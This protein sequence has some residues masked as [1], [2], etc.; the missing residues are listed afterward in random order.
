MRRTPIR[1]IPIMLIA[2]LFGGSSITAAGPTRTLKATIDVSNLETMIL[3][4]GV[5]DVNISSGDTGVVTV[6]VDL[7]PRRGGIFSSLKAAEK[8]VQKVELSSEISGTTLE[9]GLE[10]T[11]HDR[12]FEEDWTITIPV[13]L[14]VGIDLGVGDVTITGVSGAI[15]LELGVGDAVIRNFE[16]PLDIELGVGDI[17]IQGASAVCREVEAEAGVGDVRITVGNHRITGEGF[18]AHS[19]DWEGTGEADIDAE[20]GV[21][22]IRIVLD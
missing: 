21:G 9:L 14:E 2:G 6:S 10:N 16:G 7:E 12:R 5:G 4:A 19:C 15:D 17:T 3:E 11:D 18:I 8:Q 13:S 1:L 22:D 20:T